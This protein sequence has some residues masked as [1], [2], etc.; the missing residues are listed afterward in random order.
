[1]KTPEMTLF[2]KQGGAV[3]KTIALENGLIISNGSACL[4]SEGRAERIDVPDAAALA[5][6]IVKLKSD[7]A[8][9]LGSLR[10]ELADEVRIVTKHK[11]NGAKSAHTIARTAD[12]IIFEPGKAAWALLDIDAKDMPVEVKA[13]VEGAGGHW[14]AL[15]ATMP[16]LAAVERV[17]R[18]STSAGL[19]STDGNGKRIEYPKSGGQHIFL[20]VKDGTDIR[21]PFNSEVQRADFW[22]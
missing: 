20:R 8:L 18:A 13:R 14:Q 22:R 6:K 9:G 2:W 21:R 19:Y 12:S 17:T 10:A 3:T 11:L 1:M 5:E 4:M 7:E 15:C 16:E